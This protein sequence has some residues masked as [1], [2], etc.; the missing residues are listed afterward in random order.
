[1][2]IDNVIEFKCRGKFPHTEDPYACLWAAWNAHE[3]GKQ[4][5]MDALEAVGLPPL[6][7]TRRIHIRFIGSY[8][9]C[10][11]NDN[12]CWDEQPSKAAK[13]VMADKPTDNAMKSYIAEER[14]LAN[15][16]ADF[17]HAESINR[18]VGALPRDTLRPKPF[19]VAV[20][21]VPTRRLID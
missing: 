20:P 11:N 5:F 6:L 10:E 14:L 9:G 1:M 16:T 2:T 13:R 12:G 15:M 7:W 3:T 19:V 4:A 18:T 8:C 21:D 17:Y